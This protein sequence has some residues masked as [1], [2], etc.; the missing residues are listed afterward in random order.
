MAKWNLKKIV[1]FN[2]AII[3]IT[4]CVLWSCNSNGEA[5]NNDVKME[6]VQTFVASVEKGDKPILPDAEVDIVYYFM[7][8]Q[9]CP[10]CMKIEAYSKEAVQ[11]SFSEAFK[12]GNIVWRMINVDQSENRHFIKDYGLFTK[13]VVLVKLRDGKQVSW[14]NLDKIWELLGDKT[15]FQKYVTEEVKKFMEKT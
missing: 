4:A 1:L 2:F 8:T 3:L 10:S 13:S 5:E 9:R 7:T 12:K 14:K 15:T 6:V 11:K